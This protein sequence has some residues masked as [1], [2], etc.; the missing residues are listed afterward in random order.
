[1]KPDHLQN[2]IKNRSLTRTVTRPRYTSQPMRVN[3]PLMMTL[4]MTLQTKNLEHRLCF[5]PQRGLSTL[6]LLS[7]H[8]QDRHRLTRLLDRII[9][10]RALSPTVLSMGTTCG[11]IFSF[12]SRKAIWRK[13]QLTNCYPS[14]VLVLL[15][16][17]R[18]RPER[19]NSQ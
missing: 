4:M 3:H 8:L 17:E 14:Y 19:V 15:S 10:K 12:R 9:R 13:R 1:M 6:P 5:P 7:A 11:A 2:A 18:G 16:E